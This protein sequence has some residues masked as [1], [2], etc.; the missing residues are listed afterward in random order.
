MANVWKLELGGPR[1]SNQLILQEG[2][3]GTELEF[4][5]SGIVALTKSPVS[6]QKVSLVCQQS[7][8]I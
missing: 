5:A 6:S 4:A 3:V 8:R 2:G 1:R 7:V